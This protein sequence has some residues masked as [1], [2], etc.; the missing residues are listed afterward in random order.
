MRGRFPAGCAGTKWCSATAPAVRARSLLRSPRQRPPGCRNAGSSRAPSPGA[1][2]ATRTTAWEETIILEMHARGFTIRH[3]EI[4]GAERRHLFALASPAVIDYLVKLGVTAVE[5]LPIH[6]AIT[7]QHLA[8]RGLPNY[9][10][11]NTIGFFA[12]DPRCLPAGFPGGSIAEFKPRS[13]ACTKPAS[14]SCSMSS[15]TTPARATIWGRRC[16]CAASIT[17]PITGCRRTA[18]SMRTS[19]HRQ[20]AMNTDHPRV[21]ADGHGLAALLGARHACRRLPLRFVHDA[22]AANTASTTRRRVFR[23]DPPGPGNGPDEADRGAIGIVG[24]T[25]ISSAIS[26]RAGPNGTGSYRDTVRRFWKGDNGARCRH[27]V[28]RRRI[29]A[30]IFGLSRPAGVG[31]HQSRHR[32]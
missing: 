26:R 18:A 12:P 24:R 8:E 6:A 15:T 23:R 10:G 14:R 21:L 19:P 27:G 30:D 22:R 2:T 13:S 9:W 20:R 25:A 17:C 11:Y 3:P 32:A 31:Q 1:T 4:A 28:A 16:R 29:P 5:L 7:E